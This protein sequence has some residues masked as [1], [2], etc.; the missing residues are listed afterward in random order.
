MVKD[1]RNFWWL[2]S[3]NHKILFYGTEKEPTLH[4]DG[5]STPVVRAHLRNDGLFL[6]TE[7]GAIYVVDWAKH[8]VNLANLIIDK[9]FLNSLGVIFPGDNEN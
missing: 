5:N 9:A 6:G 2:L 7:S 8:R 1:R 3:Q 4:H